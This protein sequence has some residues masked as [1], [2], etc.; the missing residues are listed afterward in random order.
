M[1]LGI[2]IPTTVD[3]WKIA[4][5]A[6]ALGI[7]HAW[8]Y[9]TQML[10]TDVFVG[11][12]LAAANTSRIRLGTGVLIPSNR[13]AP[14]TANAL[15]S[16]DAM[17]PGRIDFGVG[18]GFTG[19]NTMGLPAMRLA[20]LEEYVRVVRELLAGRTVEWDAEGARRKIRFLTPEA[21]LVVPDG[22]IPLHLSAFGPR[23][24][25]L[26]ARS[27]E[28]WMTFVGRLSRGLREAR[29]MADAC[30]AAG[31]SPETLYTTAFTMGCVL[32]DGEPADSPRARAQAGPY[33]M[34]FFHAA[35]E[36]S[37]R[38]RVPAPLAAAV[39]EY[40]KLYDAYEPA[41]ARY[42]QLHTGHFM[43]VRPEEERFLTADLL[44]DLTFTG[45]APELRERIRA[46]RDGGYRQ[47]AVSLVPGHDAAMEDWVR[48]MEGV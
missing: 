23:G 40:R 16:L 44:R 11:M 24:K 37:L 2:G 19:R 28:G 46:L 25:A 22:R 29:E 21:G 6:E 48:V 26:A 47:L 15:A 36:G 39:D 27:A 34:T 30:R 8:F 10:C 43:R 3:A 14:V 17:A 7:S 45:T 12:A 13:I 41:D 33:A 4:R 31:R 20:D 38:M 35:V 5:R 32:A 42:L 9:D 18:T 1:D